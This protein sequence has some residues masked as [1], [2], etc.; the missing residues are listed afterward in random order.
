MMRLSDLR[1]SAPG[2]AL[3]HTHFQLYSFGNLANLLGTRIHEIAAGWLVWTLTG[4]A[5][6]LGLLALAE[7]VPRLLIWPLA[8]V[9]ADRFDHRRLA[10]VF[11]GIA[12]VAASAMALANAFDILQVWMVIVANA[13]FGACIAFW[14]PARMA[15]MSRVVPREDL[16]PAVAPNSV[17]SQ[18]SRVIGPALAGLVIVWAGVCTAF[19]CNAIS[20]VAVIVSLQLIRLPAVQGSSRV[21]RGILAET[22]EG[23]RYVLRHPGIGPL[24]LMIAVF[25]ITVRPIIELFPGFADAVFARGAAGLSG[26]NMVLGVG[27]LVGGLWASWRPGLKGLTTIFA[28][29]GCCG[30]L[31]IILFASTANFP[32]ALVCAGGAGVGIVLQTIISQTLVQSAV[33]DAVRGRV[34]SLYGMI[35]GAAPGLGTFLIGWAADRVGL[36]IP[37]AI[38]GTIGL[39]LCLLALARRKTLAAILERTPEEAARPVAA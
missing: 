36:Q 39:V 19:A 27:A 38:A 24:M 6:W 20:Y 32:F 33:D 12:G 26:L 7:M 35:N 3:R 10:L 34:F 15:L 5:T 22:V 14:Q 37:V 21:R 18:S 13:I 23:V 11:Q 1:S 8:G 29:S 2:R 28:V 17:I 25:M 31:A 30:S 4:S 16:A 9:M